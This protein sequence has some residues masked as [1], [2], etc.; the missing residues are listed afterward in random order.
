M[1]I[2]YNYNYSNQ[3]ITLHVITRCTR[4]NNLLEI[5]ES[6]FSPYILKIK[7]HIIF[8]T[9]VI[10]ELNQEILSLISEP[11]I[12]PIFKK[13][14]PYDYAYSLVNE[15]LDTLP[16]TDWFCIVDD[17][18]IMH[19]NYQEQIK[20]IIESN[21]DCGIIVYSQKVGGVDFTGLDIR[22]AKPENVRLQGIDVAQTTIKIEFLNSFSPKMRY[23]S[24]YC[25]DGQMLEKI[26]KE[27]KDKFYFYQDILCY[28]NKIQQKESGSKKTPRTLI[29][30]TN[31]KFNLS[32]GNYEQEAN[33]METLSIENTSNV[34][35]TISSYQ[36]DT[37]VTVGGV[38]TS[39]MLNMPIYL[40]KR[41]IYEEKISE[42]TGKNS[43][44][45]GMYYNLNYLNDKENPIV[46]VFT[47]IYNTGERLKRTYESL[48][49]QTYNN[50]EWVLTDDS[51]DLVTTN[52][53][54]NIASYDPR[55][56]YYS[57]NPK[58]KGVIGESKRRAA[59]L[60]IGNYLVELDHD[61]FLTKDALQS[62]K[63]AFNKYPDAGFCYSNCVELDENYNSFAYVEGFAFGYG[64][65]KE[66]VINGSKLKVM[67]APNMNPKTIRHIVSAPNHVRC[68]RRETYHEVGGHNPYLPIA[69]DYELV[70]RTFLKTKFIKIDK[71]L[72][73]QFYHANNTQNT[74]R[75]EIQ[76]R[77]RLIHDNYN[78][79]IYNRFKEL[80]TTDWA[81][82]GCPEAP[83]MMG[84]RFGDQEN[85]VNY[86]F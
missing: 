14:S 10:S 80:N 63:D 19:E 56:K 49:D 82:E 83:L 4:L 79:G 18:N 11:E 51:T 15:L 46:S 16:D 32:T 69:D 12:N 66:E 86:I 74:T 50:W 33:D 9:T 39:N 52:I 34:L 1:D 68:W 62:I 64:K 31:E 30:G 7:W 29:I 57:I 78:Q 81:Y 84:S 28:Y 42:S 41:W 70:V 76:R 36:P 77:V 61:D 75:A 38:D 58:T 40:R 85:F 17:D 22:E 26:I 27:K 44:L 72:Y 54:K 48:K 6:I 53:A 20:N 2:T 3:D 65:Y 67:D 43:L 21:K 24:G 13:S 5:K 25:G 73:L 47:P 55:V 8:D 60:C 45:C 71:C 35:E 23:H 37:I 59:N